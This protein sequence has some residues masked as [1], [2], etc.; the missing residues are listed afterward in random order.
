MKKVILFMFALLLVVAVSAQTNRVKVGG[1]ASLAATSLATTT[2][3]TYFVDGDLPYYMGWQI[4][5]D[6]ISGTAAGL[7]CVFEIEGSHDGTDFFDI[8][9][10]TYAGI[11]GT[12]S[13]TTAYENNSSAMYWRYLRAKYTLTDTLQCQH[14]LVIRPYVGK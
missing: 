5:L 8:D 9:T 11:V 3:Y 6:S 4:D 14:V 10:L 12:S 1:S 2:T 7:G 13:D